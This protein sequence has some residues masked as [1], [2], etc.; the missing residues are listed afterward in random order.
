[1]DGWVC[2]GRVG[3]RMAILPCLRAIVLV[4]GEI[5]VLIFAGDAAG[6][7]FVATVC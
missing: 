1:M 7:E 4:F 6:F 3:Y 2:M 5:R